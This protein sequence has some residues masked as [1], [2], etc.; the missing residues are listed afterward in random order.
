M[1]EPLNLIAA[2]TSWVGNTF[3]GGTSWVQDLID[4]MVVEPDGKCR[5][6]SGWDEA[7]N[8]RGIYWVENGKWRVETHGKNDGT[9]AVSG[10]TI[11]ILGQTWT[12]SNNV[13]T[14]PG[15]VTLPGVQK[16]TALGVYRPL[17]LLMV[18]DDAPG[19][20][21][22][23]FFIIPTNPATL[24]KTFGIPGGIGSG[25]PGRMAPLKFLTLTGCGS[26]NSGNL[27]VATSQQGV[28]LRR[29]AVTNAQN[30]TWDEQNPVQAIGLHFADCGGF[31]ETKDGLELFGKDERY[32]FDYSKPAGQEATLASWTTDIDRNPKDPRLTGD[33]G[34][35][36]KYKDGKRFLFFIDQKTENLHFYTL[37]GEV[38]IWFKTMP[39]PGRNLIVS[40]DNDCNIW[41]LSH[42][43]VQLTK[44]TGLNAAGELV[45]AATAQFSVFPQPFTVVSSLLYDSARDVMYLAGGTQQFPLEG[46][47]H[48]GPVVVKY[49]KWLT[50]KTKVWEI[51]VPWYHNEAPV[52]ERVVGE[53]WDF[54]GERLYI[55][56]LV[57][58]SRERL[59]APYDDSPGPIRVYKTT[60][61]SFVGRLLAGPEVQHDAGWIDIFSGVSA[62]ERSDGTHLVLREEVWKNKQILYTYRP[63]GAPPTP[64]PPGPS[65]YTWCAYENQS[66][67]LTG[68]CDCAYGLNGVFNYLKA[69]TG[70]ITFNNQTFGDPLPGVVKSGFFKP[71]TPPPSPVPAHMH[72]M[73][74]IIGLEQALRA[75]QDQLP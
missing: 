63:E 16:A 14:G 18:C 1:A 60:D 4:D 40:I 42:Q 61:G 68:E 49:D 72:P 50:S 51:K 30:M 28:I 57:H 6:N 23:K 12:I 58:D 66:F 56:Y 31:D 26:D 25:T 71:V 43:G 15:N 36:I 2:R 47:G 70:S 7:G 59:P 65:G 35:R 11:T 69:R 9:P 62:F 45:Y 5:T 20:H 44:C 29:F 73:S 34:I 64:K 17:L 53:A 48:V 24:V 13:A 55:G 52:G 41:S 74:D 38:A 8:E 3:S 67:A 19:Q 32:V 37:A 33:G 39:S 21:V 10:K 46:F 22:I 27:Y 75:I 54:A